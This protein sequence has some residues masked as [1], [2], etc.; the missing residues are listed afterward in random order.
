MNLTFQIETHTDAYGNREIV[1]VECEPTQDEPSEDLT[2]S[3]IATGSWLFEFVAS[4]DFDGS[5]T[6]FRRFRRYGLDPEE[7]YAACADAMQ[8]IS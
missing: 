8:Q 5:E 7:V 1:T 2:A 4:D 3:E 6:V